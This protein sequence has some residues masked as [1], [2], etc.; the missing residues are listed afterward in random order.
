MENKSRIPVYRAWSNTYNVMCPIYDIDFVNEE[1]SIDI[2]PESASI[3]IH[4]FEDVVFLQSVEIGDKNNRSLF[5][6]DI[7]KYY[8]GCSPEYYGSYI[9]YEIVYNNGG[10][11]LSFLSA[12]YGDM[13]R[14]NSAQFIS[15][16]GDYDNK[17]M[18]FDES[19]SLD[20]IEWVGNIFEN[21]ELYIKE[22]I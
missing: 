7:V 10:F 11:L 19:F 5:E 2:R 9:L 3:R 8:G 21:K 22:L 12:E 20:E 14:G 13:I 15:M 4:K 6:G 16:F 1:C 18:V 17:A